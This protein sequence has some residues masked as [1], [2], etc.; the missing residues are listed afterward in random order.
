VLG[1]ALALGSLWALIP[2]V[3][4]VATLIARTLLEERTLHAELPGYTDYTTR[5][6]FRWIPG[7]W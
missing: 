6:K 2:A 1:T 7:V 4:V 5:V 3:I